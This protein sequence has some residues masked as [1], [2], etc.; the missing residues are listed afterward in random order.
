MSTEQKYGDWNN[1][2]KWW[3]R[4]LPFLMTWSHQG[5]ALRCLNCGR[6]VWRDGAKGADCQTCGSKSADHIAWI[7]KCE[8]ESTPYRGRWG[9]RWEYTWGPRWRWMPLQYLPDYMKPKKEKT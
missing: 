6:G 9:P 1:T 8:V 7:G 4:L 5:V 3:E 2:L